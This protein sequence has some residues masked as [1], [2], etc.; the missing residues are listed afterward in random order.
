MFGEKI[1]EQANEK[2][3]S[4]KIE[5]IENC[6]ALD[7]KFIGVALEWTRWH[8]IRVNTINLKIVIDKCD[9]YD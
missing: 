4:S 8:R 9:T 6:Y 5:N 3:K 1:S 7:P 2:K